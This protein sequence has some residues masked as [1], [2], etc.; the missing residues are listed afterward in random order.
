MPK[1]P[2]QSTR[3]K[4]RYLAW[5][6]KAKGAAPDSV[7][8][9]AAAIDLFENA[10]GRKEFAKFHVEHAGRF[11]RV[12]DEAISEKTGKPLSAATVH[13]RLNAVK[14][15]F[16][17]LADQPGYKK[18]IGY[19][20][21]EYFNPSGNDTRIAKARRERPVPEIGQIRRVMDNMPASTVIEKRN[22]ALIAF[23]LL[24][25]A[26]D[27]AIASFRIAH[28]DLEKRT[29]FHD[30][31]TVRTKNRKTFISSFFPVGDD[32]AATV[33]DW[34]I[35][36]RDGE[37]F[38]GDDPLFPKTRMDLEEGS[39]APVGVERH[40]WSNAA[41]IR[42]IFKESFEAAGLP[43]FH[44][45]SFRHTLARLGEQVC[46]S[47]EE[48]KAWSQN[49][50]HEEVLTTFT[51]YGEVPGRRQVQIMDGLRSGTANAPEGELDAA[52]A[53]RLVDYFM[54]KAAKG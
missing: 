46:K 49:L 13:A 47:P 17:W 25:G 14:A 42:R 12:L 37:G 16:L 28:V 4:H 26:R 20:A 38:G 53:N 52:T 27:N 11:K 8:A 5:L 6:E 43:Y 36:L 30:A 2:P 35:Y 45:H 44:P 23:T 1:R 15:F 22:R 19:S 54:R 33:A 24:S 50:G 39:F 32:I 48:F 7:N 21:C 40:H 10:N 31:R 29:V 18:R 3:I 9:A 51:S 41:S 34:V